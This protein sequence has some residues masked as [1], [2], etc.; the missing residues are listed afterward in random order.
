[1]VL[2]PVLDPTIARRAP[3]IARFAKK[4]A[5]PQL[6]TMPT[7]HLHDN[8]TMSD[9]GTRGR[10]RRVY[11]FCAPASICAHKVHIT[12]PCDTRQDSVPCVTFAMEESAFVYCV[13]G[14]PYE[15]G[16]PP[17]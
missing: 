12:T 5:A 11:R 3:P 1:M 7:Q 15:D 10:T 6:R 14:T 9:R 16:A 4:V 13:S 17:V 2:L 8:I